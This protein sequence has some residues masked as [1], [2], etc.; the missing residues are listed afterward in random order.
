MGLKQRIRAV[1]TC[2]KSSTDGDKSFHKMLN[3]Q[4]RSTSQNSP[5]LWQL[6]RAVMS[7]LNQTLRTNRE[8]WVQ[9]MSKNCAKILRSS[10]SSLDTIKTNS[11]SRN[12]SSNNHLSQW[13]QALYPSW[14]Q[15]SATQVVS[16]NFSEHKVAW[17]RIITSQIATKMQMMTKDWT[18]KHSIRLETMSLRILTDTKNHP[19]HT[20]DMLLTNTS[21]MMRTLLQKDRL[22]QSIHNVK[23]PTIS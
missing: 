1:F 2:K 9:W 22:N 12:N 23:C 17:D 13:S 19:L 11:D 8:I 6:I 4:T 21:Q 7:N 3:Q 5:T 18:H 20:K 10:E 14:A 16:C 15:S